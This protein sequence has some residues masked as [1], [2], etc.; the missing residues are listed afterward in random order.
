MNTLSA[1]QPRA[2]SILRIIVGLMFF[3]HGVQKIFGF[4][5]GHYANTGVH[6]S[7][8]EGMSGGFEICAILVAIGLFT[9]PV[10]FILSGMMAV[11][12]WTVHFKINPWPVNNQGDAAILY[13]FIFLYFV[14]AGPGPWSVDA[15]IGKKA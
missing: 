7:S 4:P 11:G 13:S 2:L 8:L 1:W 12:Y 5:A 3:E 6:L 14:F 10:A 9:R 15:L